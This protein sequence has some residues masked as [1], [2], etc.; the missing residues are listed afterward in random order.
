LTDSQN[1]DT[2]APSGKVLYHLQFSLRATSPENFGYTLVVMRSKEVDENL[3]IE[4]IFRNLVVVKVNP[5]L[6]LTK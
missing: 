3:I 1:C 4:C 5:S 6:C 2:T